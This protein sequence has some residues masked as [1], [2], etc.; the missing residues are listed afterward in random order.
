MPL[1]LG[2]K[3]KPHHSQLVCVLP[4]TPTCLQQG[5][6]LVLPK[7]IHVVASGL[8]SV[9]NQVGTELYGCLVI[10]CSAQHGEGEVGSVPGRMWLQQRLLSETKLPSV[11]EGYFSSPQIKR[12]AKGN[13]LVQCLTQPDSSAML[14]EKQ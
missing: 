10:Q 7:Y 3:N 9:C 5:K 4:F 12:K 6:E 14:H 2:E 13:V 11:A 8:L 1:P